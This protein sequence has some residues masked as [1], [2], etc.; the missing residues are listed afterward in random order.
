MVALYD[1][2]NNF[3]YS[4]IKLANVWRDFTVMQ[5]ISLLQRYK[6][7]ATMGMKN[8]TLCLTCKF[9]KR[10][11]RNSQSPLSIWPLVWN[12]L[13]IF[14][15]LSFLCLFLPLRIYYFL[16]WYFPRN[17]AFTPQFIKE[18]LATSSVTGV[19]LSPV[20]PWMTWDQSGVSSVKQG[21]MHRLFLSFNMSTFKTTN[22][23]YD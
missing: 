3:S 14:C 5:T 10:A 21:W 2:S 6:N 15:L 22:F 18:T 17:H 19:S 16:A 11:V 23:S 9:P 1:S 7:F 13:S 8:I 12:T 20:F 4:F